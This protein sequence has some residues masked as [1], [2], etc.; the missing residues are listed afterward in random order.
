MHQKVCLC[1]FF[2]AIARF[3]ALM[4]GLL[5]ACNIVMS[6]TSNFSALLERCLNFVK[7]IRQERQIKIS[8]YDWQGLNISSSLRYLNTLALDHRLPRIAIDTIALVLR[9][10]MKTI[11]LS[12]T[13]RIPAEALS[14]VGSGTATVPREV[15]LPPPYWSK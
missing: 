8:A 7:R 2:S 6:L 1:H 15:L 10:L 9:V 14:R 11:V 4:Y 5:Y 13:N 12:P 3:L